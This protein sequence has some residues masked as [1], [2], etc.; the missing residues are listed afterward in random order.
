MWRRQQTAQTLI[1]SAA[2]FV[3]SFWCWLTLRPMQLGCS[4][5]SSNMKREKPRYSARLALSP[6]LI[7]LF[8][9]SGSI[10]QKAIRTLRQNSAWC[11]RPVSTKWGN[12]TL[13]THPLSNDLD[14]AW[15]AKNRLYSDRNLTAPAWGLFLPY[16]FISW[17]F[18]PY[19]ST[20]SSSTLTIGLSEILNAWL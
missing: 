4:A 17:S 9:T 5:R 8:K 15:L 10:W 3:E 18:W 16:H 12:W 13:A 6:P 19:E 1:I 7:M 14:N 11:V 2:I 20:T